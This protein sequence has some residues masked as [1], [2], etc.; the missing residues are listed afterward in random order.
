MFD[1]LYRF[2]FSHIKRCG[3]KAGYQLDKDAVSCGDIDECEGG[4]QGVCSHSCVN[5]QGSFHC[6]CNP[7]YLLESDGRRCKIMGKISR[8]SDNHGNSLCLFYFF[9][10]GINVQVSELTFGMQGMLAEVLVYITQ[11]YTNPHSFPTGEPYLLASVQTD[12][13]LVGLRSSSLDVLVSSAKKSI[14]S[15]DYDW[16][17]Q[18]VFWVSLDSESIKWSSLD[19]KKQGTLFK[20]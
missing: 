2:C 12:L 14:V 13:F 6:H 17:D 19:Q 15:V 16:R 5:T 8:L 9:K 18:R 11:V 7:G 4:R 1:H 20:G 3:C 10:L